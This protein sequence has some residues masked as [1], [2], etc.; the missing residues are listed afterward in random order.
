MTLSTVASMENSLKVGKWSLKHILVKLSKMHHDI[1]KNIIIQARYKCLGIF[2]IVRLQVYIWKNKNLTDSNLNGQYCQKVNLLLARALLNI[3]ILHSSFENNGR[4]KL[5]VLSAFEEGAIVLA[6][7]SPYMRLQLSTLAFEF[8]LR[9]FSL[10]L[11]LLCFDEE[12]KAQIRSKCQRHNRKSNIMNH[13]TRLYVLTKRIGRD[14]Y[15]FYEVANTAM[16]HNI[17]IL[18]GASYESISRT[19]LLF[20]EYSMKVQ[21]IELPI[22][23]FQTE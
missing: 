22:Y 1:D 9:M 5:H 15:R 11:L 18:T 8:K 17:D 2:E 3:G 16:K 13:L 23:V 21:G 19:F 4:H 14:N 12:D 7:Q 6:N 10:R 20:Q